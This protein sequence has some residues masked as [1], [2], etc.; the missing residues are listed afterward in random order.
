MMLKKNRY[1]GLGIQ[2]L[3]G[4]VARGGDDALLDLLQ[5]DLV[6]GLLVAPLGLLFPL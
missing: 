6:G 3:E 2:A 5:D 1:H 4:G